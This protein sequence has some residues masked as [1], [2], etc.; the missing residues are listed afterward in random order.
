[1][2]KGYYFYL[3]KGEAMSEKSDEK[4]ELED[5]K[6]QIKDKESEI[7]DK[8]QQ[9]QDYQN[10]LLRMQADFENYKKHVEK[11]MDEHTQQS[12]EKIITK[13]LDTY[14]DLQRALESE[15]S[16]SLREGVELIYKKLRK[17]LEEEGLEEITAEGEKFDPYKHEALM[18]EADE[19]YENGC[20]IQEL[21]KGYT[22]NSK[23]IK[24]SKVKVCKR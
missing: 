22:L 16:D 6:S 12:N 13:I 18:A 19:D 23:V 2:F 1:M 21:T 17:I 5:L 24:F 20:V 14:E 8:E 9:I 3:W 7:K 15:K 4:K 11:R 10:H